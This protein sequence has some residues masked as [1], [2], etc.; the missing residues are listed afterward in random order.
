M[1]DARDEKLVK[2]YYL[3]PKVAWYALAALFPTG[4]LAIL[5]VMIDNIALGSSGFGDL[6]LFVMIALM[7]AEGAL[8]IACGAAAK[9]GLRSEHWQELERA[10][11]GAN[12]DTSMNDAV[13]GGI[14]VASGGRLIDALGGDDLNAL[15][16]GLE[17]AGGAMA[18]YGFFETMNRMSKAA[19]A[20]GHAF[21]VKLPG[22]GRTRLAV[23]GLPLLILV[24]A[25]VPRLM[26]SASQTSAAQ[27]AAA[28]TLAA[29]ARALEPA[30]DRVSAD[31]PF[32]QRR[33]S[34]YNVTGWLTDE[35]DENIANI[36]VETDEA[37]L[38]T[39]VIYSS[40]VDIERTTEENLAQAEQAFTQFHSGL[41]SVAPA[42]TAFGGESV[43]YADM[44]L[45][46]APNLPEEFR[47]AFLANDYYTELDV[48]MEDT[49][50]LRA[51]ALFST[52][53]EDEFDEYTDTSIS[54]YL[55]AR[56]Y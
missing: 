41:A 14:G 56:I 35:D 22:L 29:V 38:V 33:G 31:D 34:G 8:C 49:G 4:A 37:G 43:E 52:E 13:V 42:D 32:E 19:E 36:T 23:L 25:F 21:G 40:E 45:V 55:Q 30:C 12:A 3:L 54:I 44:G 27:E 20:V 2:K 47:Q 24:L 10:A 46:A 28:Q 53:P 18:A 5:L 6:Q 15:G 1:L 16:K 50:T 7:I 11:M 26:E 51:W 48:D 39:G 17:I 9:V